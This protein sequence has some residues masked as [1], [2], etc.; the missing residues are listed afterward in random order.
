MI[1][2]R[3]LDCG[4]NVVMEK[5]PHVRS[6]SMGIWVKAGATDETAKNSGISHLLNT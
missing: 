1:E 5:I 3:Q 4:I 2:R 6:V